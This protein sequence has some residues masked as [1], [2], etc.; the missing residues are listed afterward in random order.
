MTRIRAA[1]P[2]RSAAVLVVALAASLAWA[3]AETSNDVSPGHDADA[4]TPV[5]ATEQ[6][7]DDAEAKKDQPPA[8]ASR[9]KY[10]SSKS[11]ATNRFGDRPNYFTDVSKLMDD[12][13]DWSWFDLGVEHRTRFELRDDFYNAGG[14]SDRR[15]LMRSRAYLGVRK[16]MDPLRFGFEFQDSRAFG[17]DFPE[18]TGDVNE[19]E[20]LQAFGELYFE[21]PLGD[22]EPLSFR[23]GRMSFDAVDRRLVARNRFRNS[24]N[25][26][27]GFRL[28]IGDEQSVWEI[29]TFAFQPVERRERQFDHG[30]DERWFYGITGYWRGWSPNIT[31]EPYYFILDEDRKGRTRQDRE[32]HTLGVHGFGLFGDSGF[33]YDFDVAGQFG[34]V[35]SDNH[36]AFAAH[37][38][39][40]YS[41]DHA[42]KPRLAA[43]FDYATGDENPNDGS[44]ERFDR[45]FGAAH[46]FYGHSDQFIWS[47]TINP[48]LYLSLK[49][50]NQLHVEGFY[51]AYWLE[52]D[53]DSWASTGLV[54][55]DGRSGNFVGQE[56]DVRV[57]YKIDPRALLDI[58]Y[59][60]FFPG[61]VP[62]N[63]SADADDSDFFYVAMTLSL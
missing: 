41:F 42:W 34:E 2:Q 40:G 59:A 51:R 57:R 46:N 25:S 52:S 7:V 28:R 14:D 38:E 35:G 27:D 24:T 18:T 32:I 56:L 33:D 43:M 12:G 60:H 30:D 5:S 8:T 29:D 9:R 21:D 55:R 13:E 11:P 16:V 3:Q 48:A 6:P 20:L 49:P 37:A 15:F 31:L 63:T 50:T 4:A 36:C 26:F 45:L 10:P 39:V 53:R 47:N 61:D 1:L 22:G 44:S 54:D 19:H 23:V 62:R 17:N 58:G